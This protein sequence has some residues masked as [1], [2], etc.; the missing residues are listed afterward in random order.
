MTVD[1]LHHKIKKRLAFLGKDVVDS[2]NSYEID[3]ALN[4][5]Q[6]AIIDDLYSQGLSIEKA[7]KLISSL[8]YPM[9]L[10]SFVDGQK[11]TGFLVTLTPS[12]LYILEE[13][14]TTLYNNKVLTNVPVEA[15]S[16]DYY[17][18]NIHNPDKKPY[19]DLIWRLTYRDLTTDLKRH[20]LITDGTYTITTYHATGIMKPNDISIFTGATS[21]LDSTLH[22]ELIARSIDIIARSRMLVKENV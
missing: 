8:V 13:H 3:S 17:N 14:A 21:G 11:P 6:I 16:F 1:N 10:S 18:A 9:S 5:S 2:I 22:E 20:E 12:I 15:K 7:N 19:Y 4:T